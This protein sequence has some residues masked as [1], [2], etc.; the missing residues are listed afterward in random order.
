MFPTRKRIAW[1]TCLDIPIGLEL[2]HEPGTGT[3]TISQ[4]LLG[5]PRPRSSGAAT[6]DPREAWLAIVGISNP[7]SAQMSGAD[8]SIPLTFR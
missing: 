8:F 7:G 3:A 5:K 2:R 4:I 1:E 6:A